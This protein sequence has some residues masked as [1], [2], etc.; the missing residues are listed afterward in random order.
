ME[1]V[2]G[3]VVGALLVFSYV[4]VFAVGAEVGR[5]REAKRGGGR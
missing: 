2:I 1:F 4:L 5:Q 3:S